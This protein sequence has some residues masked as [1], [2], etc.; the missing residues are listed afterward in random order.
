MFIFFVIILAISL[1]ITIWL[2]FIKP[3]FRYSNKLSHDIREAVYPGILEIDKTII[4]I[5][6][7]AIVLT[8]QFIDKP[9]LEKQ[10]LIFSWIGFS[11]SIGLGAIIL[12]AHYTHRL[13]DKV[14]I[15]EFK[16]LIEEQEK[17]QGE[18]QG[19]EDECSQ[20][21]KHQHFLSIILFFLI[22]FQAIFLLVSLISLLLFGVKNVKSHIS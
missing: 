19:K 21:L 4:T 16:R 12:L 7:A 22:Y 10:Y 1:F 17:R 15:S 13:T 5:S 6:S 18:S 20:I 11:I 2:V 14:M 8:V 9:L 3:L